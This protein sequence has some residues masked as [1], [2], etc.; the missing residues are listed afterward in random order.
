MVGP[1]PSTCMIVT[2]SEL[3]PTRV[4]LTPAIALLT[5]AIVRAAGAD[6]GRD[7]DPVG[8]GGAGVCT[9]EFLVPCW[10]SGGSGTK[11]YGMVTCR[12]AWSGAGWVALHEPLPKPQGCPPGALARVGD[13]D[14]G[15]E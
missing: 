1:A 13:R 5:T 7:N 3:V 10:I 2:V 4:K 15:V 8:E 12:G 9:M 6:A 14:S 11:L